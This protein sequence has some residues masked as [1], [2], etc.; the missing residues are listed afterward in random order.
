MQAIGERPGILWQAIIVFL[1]LLNSVCLFLIVIS[2]IKLVTLEDFA[3]LDLIVSIVLLI[4]FLT[5]LM[6][7]KEK[8][9]YLKN[10]WFLIFSFIPIYI[11]IPND[12]FTGSIIFLKI[13]CII[14]I[15]SLYLFA[16]KFAREVIKYQEKTRL[17]YAVAIFMVVFFFCSF[18]FYAVEHGLNPE[19]ATY[20]DSL[21]FVLQTITTVGYGDIIP[22]TGVGR[23][24]G[25]ISMFSAL[26]L[27]SIITSVATFSLIEKFR[28]GSEDLTRKT[29]EKVETFT[30]KL[31][32]INK[33]IDDL[34]K[35]NELADLQ[36]ELKEIKS[37]IQSLKKLIK[38]NNK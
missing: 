10:Y 20:E 9:A 3:L 23:L 36:N 26:A 15:I 38:E 30:T 8:K 34:D 17:V 31:D 33:R 22:I 24:M 32:H 28:K 18:I 7:N 6:R 37:E 12:G 4:A 13:F 11:F 2:N 5:G 14:K 21:W 27:T 16:Q 1:I 19:V 35:S 25:V 29:K